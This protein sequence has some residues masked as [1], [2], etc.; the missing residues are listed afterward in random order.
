MNTTGN[1]SSFSSSYYSLS[2]RGTFER[3]DAPV[4]ARSR[5]FAQ[6]VYRYGIIAD[7]AEVPATRCR[8]LD[9]NRGTKFVLHNCTTSR[10]SLDNQR[11]QGYLWKLEFHSSGRNSLMEKSELYLQPR[12]NHSSDEPITT[13]ILYLHVVPPCVTPQRPFS[14]ARQFVARFSTFCKKLR[15][16]KS[17]GAVGETR[18]SCFT[19]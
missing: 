18:A 5:L 15:E 19:F 3:Q 1:S 9:E 8:K 10:E 17:T 13:A 2:H 11:T 12:I 7:T 14:P 16:R 6:L 4:P